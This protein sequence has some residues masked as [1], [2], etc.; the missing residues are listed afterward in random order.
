M[1]FRTKSEAAEIIKDGIEKI[2]GLP[3]L[4]SLIESSHR[5]QKSITEHIADKS[6]TSK[7]LSAQLKKTED[8]IREKNNAINELTITLRQKQ[9]L[10]DDITN[11]IQ[12]NKE[13]NK[14]QEAIRQKQQ[15]KNKLDKFNNKNNLEFKNFVFEKIPEVLIRK[16][17]ENSE[18]IFAKL[19]DEDKIPPSISRGA[20]DKILSTD[21]LRCICNRSFTKDDD[22]WKKLDEIKQAIIDD[23]ISQG[24]TQGRGLISHILDRSRLEKVDE[25]FNHFTNIR[26]ENIR[27]RTQLLS[28][29]DDL[30]EQLK[31]TEFDEGEDLGGKKKELWSQILDLNSQISEL[32]EEVEN[33]DKKREEQDS[34]LQKSIRYEK[35]YTTELNKISIIKAIEKFAKERRKEIVDTLRGKAE[36]ATSKY[37]LES[38]PEKE[39]FDHVT[40]FPNY[41][42]VACDSD[43]LEKELS[44]GQAHVLGL[45][46]VAGC[47]QITST[48]TFLFIDSPLHNISGTSRNDISQV[49]LKYLPGV[50]IVL[51]VTDSEYLHGDEK[52]ALPVRTYLNPNNRVMKE[53]EIFPKITNGIVSREVKDYVRSD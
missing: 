18:K 10:Y 36:T 20:I 21:P 25:S 43:N 51:F 12:K 30:H 44:K 28:E 1:K 4:D 53:Y 23:D 27:L 15:D 50:Q 8:S 31:Q 5:T 35:A 17:L 26:A 29:I 6:V 40:I 19:E 49:Y 16:T 2:S 24:I 42:I 32:R 47:R 3:I 48:K 7:G 52:G 14:I 34:N 45:S 46:Y 11:K 33:F 38:A 9:A 13:G 39:T 37:F 41:N 22:V